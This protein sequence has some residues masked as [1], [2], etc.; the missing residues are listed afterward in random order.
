MAQL[1]RMQVPPMPHFPGGP[2]AFGGGDPGLDFRLRGLLGSWEG[3]DGTKY[4]LTEDTPTS[5]TV[6]TIRPS[7]ETRTTRGL[8][9][10]ALDAMVRWGRRGQYYLEESALPDAAL[11]CEAR[12]LGTDA[13]PTKHVV[14]DWS[15]AAEGRASPLRDAS[16]P[17][18]RGFGR[19][20]RSP[21][22]QREI[23][24]EKRGSLCHVCGQRGHWQGDPECPGQM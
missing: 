4:V 6:K 12:C 17:P 22:R 18:A 15:R 21:L 23:N 5:L 19:D 8:V 24:R 14:F 20:D 10:T 2:L 16:C 3:R 11:W 7:G 1:G 9:S 13:M